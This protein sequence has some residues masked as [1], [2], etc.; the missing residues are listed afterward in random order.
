[1]RFV[2]R[3]TV[4]RDA[5]PFVVAGAIAAGLIGATLLWWREWLR[6]WIA[7]TVDATNMQAMLATLGP[8]ASL[9]SIGLLTLQAVIAPLP[10]TLLIAAN[11]AIFGVWKGVLISWIG[12]LSG[13]L[14]SYWLGRWL[15]DNALRRWVDKRHYR[16]LD[17]MRNDRGFVVVLAARLMPLVSMDFIGYMAGAG[18][19]Q[20]G[21]YLAASAIGQTPAVIAYT[22]LGD[23]LLA[24]R[25]V[26]WRV[27]LI[28]LAAV[29]LA[30]LSQWLLRR[31]R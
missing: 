21:V 2:R 4:R 27:A 11:G 17:T 16:W 15:G 25:L 1:M 22:L 6:A 13:A 23:D 31:T 18:R 24:A 7:I 10:S 28:G 3:F 29:A 20:V 26:M 5:L 30:L 12:V 9:M 19:M 14:A 8:W